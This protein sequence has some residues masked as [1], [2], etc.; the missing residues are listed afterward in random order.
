MLYAILAYHEEGVV[1]AMSEAEDAAL[2]AELRQVHQRL[3]AEERL[4]PAARL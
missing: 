1:Q 3:N 4:G 2:M